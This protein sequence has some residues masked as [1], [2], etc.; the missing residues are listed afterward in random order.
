MNWPV[1]DEA[2]WI[3]IG[4]A[5]VLITAGVGLGILAGYL[6]VGRLEQQK[7]KGAKKKR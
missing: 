7:A 4:I 1:Y 3:E 6:K 2:M 5:L